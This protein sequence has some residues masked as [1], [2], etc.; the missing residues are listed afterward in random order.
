MS[1]TTV[2]RVCRASVLNDDLL[3]ALP[4]CTP[5]HRT[6]NN[7]LFISPTWGRGQETFGEEPTLVSALTECACNARVSRYASCGPTLVL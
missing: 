7:N 2:A 6:P 4:S 3:P 1:S 5:L